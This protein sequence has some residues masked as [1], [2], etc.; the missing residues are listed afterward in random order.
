MPSNLVRRDSALKKRE[1]ESFS[2]R[3]F[4]FF[5]AQERERAREEKREEGFPRMIINRSLCHHCKGKK[6][7]RGNIAFFTPPFQAFVLR[8]R[9][10]VSPVCDTERRER[11]YI[12][13]PAFAC[14]IPFCRSAL[15]ITRKKVSFSF[16]VS[17]I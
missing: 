10:R 12:F 6:R 9:E 1:R 3:I 13:L 14:P 11:P 8:E 15:F 4:L 7:R 5:P 17:T 2:V 16:F